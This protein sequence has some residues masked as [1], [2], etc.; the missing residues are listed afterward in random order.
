[1]PS[2]NIISYFHPHFLS[3]QR[4]CAA[5]FWVIFS[6]CDKDDTTTT[7]SIILLINTSSRPW[8][9]SLIV[10]LV[11]NVI[12]QIGECSFLFN[13]VFVLIARQIEV[14][15]QISRE[16]YKSTGFNIDIVIIVR[17]VNTRPQISVF[18]SMYNDRKKIH[19]LKCQ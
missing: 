8:N 11:F 10:Y 17:P 4:L 15:F 18:F 7:I 12:C 14:A 1:M 9:N 5:S 16:A 6:W 3:N 19:R 2:E 13:L